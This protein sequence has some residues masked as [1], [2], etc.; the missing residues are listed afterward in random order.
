MTKV[1]NF[2]GRVF[3]M[4]GFLFAV[5][6][7]AGRNLGVRRPAD[8]R[9]TRVVFAFCLFAAHVV[10]FVSF[11]FILLRLVCGSCCGA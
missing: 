3:G 8:L 7:V 10:L 11:C 6:R 9:F 1:R 4:F 2:I 5:R